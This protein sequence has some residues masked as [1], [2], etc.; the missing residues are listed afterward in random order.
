[1]ESIYLIQSYI[2]WTRTITLILSIIVV[3]LSLSIY[4]N[5]AIPI[6]SLLEDTMASTTLK[7]DQILYD[8]ILDRRLIATLVASQA[9]IFCPLFLLMGANTGVS[10]YTVISTQERWRIITEQ[11]CQFLL[12]LGLALSWIFCVS[13]DNKTDIALIDQNMSTTFS[14]YTVKCQLGLYIV[15]VLKCIIILILLSEVIAIW[16]ASYRYATLLIRDGQCI[17]LSDDEEYSHLPIGYKKQR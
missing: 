17:H 3:I 16:L 6:F 10:Q 13:F 8:M 11:F 2:V 4:N 14:K 7:G 1:M 9:S 12:P 15:A 5:N